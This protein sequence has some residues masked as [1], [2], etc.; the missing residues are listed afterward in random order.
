MCTR[1]C[2]CVFCLSPLARLR[3][4]I[5][6][7]MQQHLSQSNQT[8]VFTFTTSSNSIFLNLRSN[9]LTETEALHISPQNSQLIEFTMCNSFDSRTTQYTMQRVQQLRTLK[10]WQTTVVAARSQEQLQRQRVVAARGKR[11]LSLLFQ[12]VRQVSCSSGCIIY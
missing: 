2:V 7:L 11:A 1:V 5:L 4:R 9:S 12:A 10:R 8:K 6:R 3:K